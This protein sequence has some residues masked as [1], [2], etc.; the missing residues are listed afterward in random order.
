MKGQRRPKLDVAIQTRGR[1]LVYFANVSSHREI[2]SLGNPQLTKR[3]FTRLRGRSGSTS[4]VRNVPNGG[5][6]YLVRE[7]SSRTR[8]TRVRFTFPGTSCSVGYHIGRRAGK[9]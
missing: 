7:C 6:R 8:E 5:R 2:H 9:L 3:V 4:H 1:L